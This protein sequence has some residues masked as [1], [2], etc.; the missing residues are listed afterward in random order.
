METSDAKRTRQRIPRIVAVVCALVVLGYPLSS[1]PAVWVASRGY[2]PD[3]IWS[4]VIV[5]YYPIEYIAPP[6]T[7]LGKLLH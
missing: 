2:L 4:A 5:L 7:P 1:G 6:D 3:A